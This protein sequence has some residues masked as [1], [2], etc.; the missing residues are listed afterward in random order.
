[1]RSSV[2]FRSMIMGMAIGAM[3]THTSS[4]DSLL[5]PQGLI[6][7]FEKPAANGF[8]VAFLEPVDTCIVDSTL[9]DNS[10]A[11]WYRINS[12]GK[13]GWVRASGMAVR[14]GAGIT[15]P[16]KEGA[17]SKNDPDVKR[18]YRAL[19]GHADWPRRIVKAIREGTI[20]LDMNEEQVTASW[21]EPFR[22]GKAFILG[23]GQQE[24]WYYKDGNGAIEIVFLNNGRVVGWSD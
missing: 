9:F 20:C 7:L 3:A 8:P 18:R 10:V 2:I 13:T 1:M 12:S 11:Q 4:D 16:E 21:G 22:K 5:F 14:G 23:A 17:Y 6:P 15:P 19:E 24:M